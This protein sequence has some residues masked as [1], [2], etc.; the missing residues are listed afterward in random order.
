M[1]KSGIRETALGDLQL[2][3][4]VVAFKKRFYPRGWA[5]Y[6][7]AKPGTLKLIPPDRILKAMR[8]DYGAMQD[9]IFGRRPT[10]DEIVDGLAELEGE[11]NALKPGG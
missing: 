1:S 7:Q 2:L 4:N 8:K 5:N 3:E 6:D 11:I 10:F 9:M